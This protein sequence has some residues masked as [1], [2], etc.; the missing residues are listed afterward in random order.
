M[1]SRKLSD[2][3]GREFAR[4]RQG[5]IC[6]SSALLGAEDSARNWDAKPSI[7]RLPLPVHAR[8]CLRPGPSP[9]D[10]RALGSPERSAL[11]HDDVKRLRLA[12][13]EIE[14]TNFTLE[15]FSAQR[16]LVLTCRERRV[17]VDALLAEVPTA[18]VVH[19]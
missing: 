15:A 10:R 12:L 14:Q 3:R 9:D 13:H 17:I 5:T 8:T 18:A 6:W 1:Q 16:E 7:P 2:A 11:A 19:R 4:P